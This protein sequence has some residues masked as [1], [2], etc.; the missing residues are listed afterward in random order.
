MKY[1]G[2]GGFFVSLFLFCRT[3]T[4]VILLC[5]KSPNRQKKKKI[6]NKWQDV[7]N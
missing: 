2:F 5:L 3:S 1:V 6:L 4:Q 7:F